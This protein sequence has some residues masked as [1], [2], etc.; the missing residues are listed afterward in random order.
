MKSQ[1]IVLAARPKGMPA[2]DNFRFEDKELE[3]V[4]DDEV[5]IKATY[6]SVDPY[7]RG[8]M[9]D[10]KS[11]APSFQVGQP[12]AGGIIAEVIESKS[13]SLKIGDAVFGM[14]PWATYIVEKAENLRKIDTSSV[15]STYYLG[16]LGMP[17]LTAYFGIMDIGR[18]KAG[19]TVLISG[20]AGA[21]GIVA[22]QIAKLQGAYVVGIA[23]T[24]EK[25]RILKE[26]FSYDEAINYNTAKV[27]RKS[28]AAACP[29]GV[30]VYFDNVGGEITDA[31]VIN[32]NFHS[33]FVLCGQI[34]LYNNTDM[35]VG[36]AI[37]PRLLTRSV[38][39]QGFIVSNYSNRFNEGFEN[40]AK[41]LGEGKLKYTETIIS[42]F[43]K[44]P[45]AFLGL[46]SGINNGKMIVK[47]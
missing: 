38:M 11:Y 23:G 15:P 5:L 9:N 31:A 1:Q 33:R 25:C 14:L 4:K 18:P 46:F 28:I 10:V 47:I 2:F 34:S 8:R 20:A 41:W 36:P 7:M 37:L 3:E 22:G 43:N 42:G 6:I 24:D 45:E 17:G 13:K 35:P 32:L 27:L 12:I 21:V 30:D 16:I 39:L 29:N 44:L 19:E 40:L 26:K